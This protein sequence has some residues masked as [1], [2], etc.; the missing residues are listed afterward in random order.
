MA[1]IPGLVPGLMRTMQRVPFNDAA[2]S[3][4]SIIRNLT[5]FPDSQQELLKQPRIVDVLLNL[6]NQDETT[7]K[8]T[9]A[10][11]NLVG[12]D[13]IKSELLRSAKH[14]ALKSIVDI[15]EEVLG[16]ESTF[17]LFEPLLS[18]RYLSLPQK[19]REILKDDLMP[20][21]PQTLRLAIDTNDAISAGHVIAILS[22]FAFDAETL[23]N[24]KKDDAELLER[25]D[26]VKGKAS[27]GGGDQEWRSVLHDVEGLIWTLRGGDQVESPQKGAIKQD[28]VM[29]SYNWAHKSVALRVANFLRISGFRV[30]QDVENMKQNVM[31]SMAKAVL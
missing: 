2:E 7:T 14:H 28:Q 4:L 15:L 31:E 22:Q 19:N 27:N 13:E 16:G 6:T 21:L 5:M 20:I 26:M 23:A 30:W 18:L 8:A 3:A 29:I 24:L 12:K 17:A 11:A 9:M 1:T 10:V 25:L